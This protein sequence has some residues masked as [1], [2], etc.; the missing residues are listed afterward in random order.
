MEIDPNA[1][2]ESR[3]MSTAFVQGTAG[4]GDVVQ[5]LSDWIVLEGD[6]EAAGDSSGR[7]SPLNFDKV[8]SHGQRLGIYAWACMRCGSG[9]L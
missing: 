1:V 8:R 2:Q 9:S 5:A 4:R 6:A 3:A 7:F